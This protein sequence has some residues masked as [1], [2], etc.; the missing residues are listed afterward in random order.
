MLVTKSNTNTTGGA[1]I[2][3]YTYAVNKLGQRTSVQQAGS[4]FSS[5][6]A[7]N[8]YGYDSLGQVTSAKRFAGGTLAAPTNP[9]VGQ[10]FALA[11]DS[12]GN[13]KSAT[14]G[15]TATA[16]TPNAINQYTKVNAA[17]PTYDADG[18][19][20]T[21]GVQTCQWDGENRLISVTLTESKERRTAGGS[22]LDL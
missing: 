20:L 13:R 2:S 18:N 7:F 11:Y 17:V 8:I 12:I 5:V 16:Y 4:A 6:P 10:Q 19:L 14:D 1:V 15:V 3:S 21:D 9:V 22:F